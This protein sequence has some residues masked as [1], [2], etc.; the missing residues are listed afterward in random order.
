[1]KSIRVVRPRALAAAAGLALVASAHGQYGFVSNQSGT[2]TDISSTGTQI[3]LTQGNT[4]DG[5]GPFTSSVTNA[6]VTNAS[7]W[8]ATNG[9]ISDGYDGTYT[10]GP[11]PTGHALGLFPLWDDLVLDSTGAKIVH[12]SAVEGGINVEIIEWYQARAYSPSNGTGNFEVKIFQTGPTYV[13][14]L[15]QSTGWI[16]A[17]SSAT[18]GV[19][20]G[21]SSYSQYTY[22][23]AN[24]VPNNT[25]LSVVAAASGACCLP[26]VGGCAITGQASCTAQGGTYHGDNSTCAAANCPGPVLG[27][28]VIVGDVYDISRDGAAGSITAYSIGTDSCNLGDVGVEWYSGTNL[29][30]V[31]SGNMFRLKTVSGSSRFEQIGMSWCK[32]GFLA[33]NQNYCSFAGT[34]TTPSG[35]HLG[36]HG[37]SDIYSS[38]LNGDQTNMSARSEVNGTSGA[39]PNPQIITGDSSTA[40]GM[41]CQCLTADVDP[42]QNSGAAYFADAH[43]IVPDDAQWPSGG[44]PGNTATNGL[45]NA[46]YRQITASTLLGSPTFS[47]ASH[48][49]SPGIQAWKDQDSS[50]TLVNA[51]F[52]DN[53]IAGVPITGRFIVGAKATSLGGGVYHYEYAIY[54]LNADRAGGSFSVPIQNGAQIT[55]VGFHA[56][57][58]HSG[59]PID[60]TA[61]DSAV[62][63]SAVTWAPHPFSPSVNSNSIRWGTLYNFR[64]DANVAPRTGNAT[65]GLFKAGSPS[66]ITV[67]GLPIPGQSCYANCDGSTSVP[68]LNVSD[69]TCFLQRFA[70]GDP[71]ANC[72][73]STSV[74]TLNVSDFTCF[75]QKFALGCP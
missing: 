50:V 54:N 21:T 7:L 75:L 32:H 35:N 26:N 43:Y 51:D 42:A 18:I 29:T 46:S 14:F 59:E 12:K 63:A 15:Y 10:N 57:F 36:P 73:G 65:L 9:F 44:V 37:C 16:G 71:Y 55:N 28:D 64:F 24:A 5:G 33:T 27:P 39:Y 1:M 68:V 62:S 8:A 49:Q 67:G 40:I 11:L 30:P 45:N 4:D 25:V 41:R 38:G 61:W 31:I 66:A 2:F 74:P 70:L 13:Q 58:Y 52:S 69:F 48:A 34:C 6:L 22:N 20:W 56:P 72:D 47:A 60:N 23:V 53:A 17:G 19:Q 3:T